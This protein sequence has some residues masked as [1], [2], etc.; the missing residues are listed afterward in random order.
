LSVC[1]VLWPSLPEIKIDDDDDDDD[2]S[3]PL[4][5]RKGN[6]VVIAAELVGPFGTWSTWRSMA[7]CAGM[8]SGNRT[9]SKSRTDV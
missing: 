9:T 8:L 7:W 5:S 4:Q 3:L 1:L 2:D 6:V